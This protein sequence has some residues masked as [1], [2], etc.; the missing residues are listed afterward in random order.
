MGQGKDD[1][2]LFGDVLNVST[3]GAYKGSLKS[4]GDSFVDTD[5]VGSLVKG[6]I[7]KKNAAKDQKNEAEKAQR[8]AIKKRKLQLKQA[9][10]EKEAAGE[11]D[12]AK[13]NQ[14]AARANGFNGTI[15]TG[16]KL[17]STSSNKG[18]GKTLLGL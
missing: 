7:D 13:S 17:G 5:I 18:A 15:L 9:D 2:S 16:Q 8:A 6:Q 1:N 10:A 4:F 12:T 11:R 3:L 14:N